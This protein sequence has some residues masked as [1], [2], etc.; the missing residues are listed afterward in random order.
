MATLPAE[1]SAGPAAGGEAVA[2]AAAAAATEEEE[3]EAR[4]LL[5]TLQAAEGEAAAA[6]GAGAGEAASGAEGPGSPGVP[7]SPPE[8]AAEP[9]TGLRF[10]PEQVACVC[11]A[12]L[13]AGHAGRLSRFLGALPPAERLRGSDPVLRARALVAFQRG[14]YAELYRLLESRP[15]PAAHHAFLQ[16]LYLRARYHEAERARGRALGAVDKYRLRKKFPLP[17]TIWDGEETVYCFKERSR[18]ALKACYRGN[19]YPTPDEKRR[20]ATLTGLSLTQVSNWFKNRRQ[21]DRT[22]GGGGAPCKSESDGNPATE[23]EC[24]RSPEDLDRA[25]APVA[26]EAPAQG[27]IFLA[28]AAPPAPCAASSSI[29]VNGSFL[30]AGSSPAV[31]LNG[32]P[33]IINSLALGE[34][35]GL[36]PLLLTGGSGPPASQPGP[37]GPSEG[38]TSLVLDPQTGEV[39]LEEAQPEAAKTKEAQV[40]A[41]GPAGEEAAGPLPQVVPGPPPA[42][43]FPLPPGPVPSVAAPQV[44]PLSPPPGYPAGLG[45]A[46]PLLNLPQVV[47]T[48]QVVTLPQ[49][50]GP[51]QLLA[52][53]PGSPVKVAAAGPANVH[54]INSGVGVTALQLPSATAPGNFLLANP[55]SGS[56]IVT[57]VAVQQGKIIL[58]ATF[59]TS[60]LVS[61]VL[62]PAPGLALPL[63]PDP[64]ISVPEGALPVAPSPALPDVHSLGPLSAPPPPPPVPVP[65]TASLPFSPDSSGLLPGFPAPPPEGLLLSPAAMPVWPAGLELSAGPEGLLEAEKGLGTQAPHTVLRLPD[66]DPEGLLLGSTAGGEVDEGLEAEPKVLTQLQSV[67]VEDPL[68]L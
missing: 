68:E 27:S 35:S 37:Q 55:V 15:F 5:Q 16:D 1:P 47:P 48:S 8:A 45:P 34:A 17:K 32:S 51:L 58:T 21:R 41:S 26:A 6:A 3:E 63:K 49:A 39:R 56:P 23:D 60:M 12:L 61:Q 24:S 46:S 20:L 50:V 18:A 66:P 19:R 14:E 9:P 43:P 7:G 25:V 54:L 38:K 13:Q 62:P 64:A 53:G 28:G 31:L 30:A 44:V 29:L 22:G 65:A 10:S 11:E 52:A 4:Q 67:P 36:G 42:A 59:P 40:A 57:G 33:V 2:A